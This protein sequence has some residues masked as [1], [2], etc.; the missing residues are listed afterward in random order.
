MVEFLASAGR[1]WPSAC[2]E[3]RWPSACSDRRWPSACSDRR[4]PSACSERRWPA[5]CSDTSWRRAGSSLRGS[6]DGERVL[7]PTDGSASA[8]GA[9]LGDEVGGPLPSTAGAAADQLR[10]PVANS[11]RPGWGSDCSRCEVE[12]LGRTCAAVR[13]SSRSGTQAAARHAPLLLAAPAAQLS[14]THK[15]VHIVRIGMLLF[16]QR[17]AAACRS[18]H[19]KRTCEGPLRVLTTS[20]VGSREARRGRRWRR[21]LVVRVG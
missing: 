8:G 15:G 12:L 3:R 19:C 17:G 16:V 7:A 1:R 4:W 14:R 2:S 5:A 18:V 6:S 9:P 11:N 21:R 20:Q 10:V 13:G